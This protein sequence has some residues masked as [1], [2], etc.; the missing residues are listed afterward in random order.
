M[1]LVP[2]PGGWKLCNCVVSALA[3]TA[4]PVAATLVCCTMLA[5]GAV[6]SPAGREPSYFYIKIFFAS[7]RYL[8]TFATLIFLSVKYIF[9]D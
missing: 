6:L 1:L 7:V 2:V 9:C 3:R 8:K 4:A 5:A